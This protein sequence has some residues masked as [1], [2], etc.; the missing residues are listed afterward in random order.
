MISHLLETKPDLNRVHITQVVL[1]INILLKHKKIFNEK[2]Q[3]PFICSL[4]N[5]LDLFISSF[6]IT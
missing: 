3:E 6:S 1:K 4:L 5:Y 2:C